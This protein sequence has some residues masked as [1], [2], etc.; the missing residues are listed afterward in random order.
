MLVDRFCARLSPFSISVLDSAFEFLIWSL[1]RSFRL[2]AF[3]R[4][5]HDGSIEYSMLKLN[6]SFKNV[7]RKIDSVDN[8]KLDFWEQVSLSFWIL[9]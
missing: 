8:S 5:V 1:C 7:L 4:R 2:Q 9:L 3:C 6:F